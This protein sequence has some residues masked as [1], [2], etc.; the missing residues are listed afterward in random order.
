VS[1]GLSPVAIR[2][3]YVVLTGLRWLPV[4]ITVPVTVLLASA[5]GLSAAQIGVVFAVHS[6]VALLLELPTGGLADAIGN[7]PVLALSVVLGCSG[8]LVTA[9]AHD[10]AMFALGFGL[11]GAGRALDS[12]PLE[13]WFVDAMHQAGPAADVTAGLSHAAAADGAGLAIGAILGGLAPALAAGAGG[14]VL[15]LPFLL[16][17]ALDVV[18]LIALLA[19]VVP[20]GGRRAV[21][22]RTALLP[23]CRNV[24]RLVRETGGAVREDGVLRRLLGIGF[25]VGVTLA[26]LE[27]LGPLR[28]ARLA[29][30]NT[31][32]T[33]VFGVVMAV[34]FGAS[35]LGS[36]LSGPARRA[37]RGS[38]AIATT[39]VAVLA[40]AAVLGTALSPTVL[41]GA[42]TYALFYLANAV[43]WPLRQQ[44]MHS[45]V[46]TERRNTTVSAV[47]LA[48]QIGGVAGSLL[49]TRLADATSTTVGLGAAAMALLVIA[50]LSV[51]LP[52]E[53]ERGRV[54]SLVDAQPAAAGQRDGGHPA[55]ALLADRALELH[56]P[57]GEL[58][59]GLV[60]VVADQV[61]LGRAGGLGG[62]HGHLGRWELQ[63]Q[64]AAARIHVREPEDVLQERPVGVGVAAVED[65][66][67]ATD[68]GPRT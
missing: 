50:A 23:G 31:A 67:R 40:A 1:A 20:L 9:T 39:A 66:V 47:S 19:L 5:R 33:A 24:P 52:S 12:G 41:A 18:Y 15:A 36:V 63:D 35:A 17:A 64:P 61:E 4:G 68:H 58:G 7:R 42:T 34:S 10:V 29:G 48:G 46:S 37:A 60:D 54:P 16:A 65:D 27:L 2:R 59:D 62:V 25:L 32:G 38:T 3:R 51:R 14:G 53:L 13:S 49:I 8:L 11:I 21:S 22:S 28:F 55:P 6:I 56:A 44:L 43:G 45:R 57:G 30:G 26:T